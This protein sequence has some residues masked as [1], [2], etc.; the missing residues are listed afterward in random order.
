[1]G[2]ECGL[3]KTIRKGI[4]DKL[5]FE[6]RHESS[7]STSHVDIFRSVPERKNGRYKGPEAK[8]CFP[9][10]RNSKTSVPRLKFT[11]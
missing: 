8:A 7:E 5:T 4:S 9:Y 10:S 6:Q 2:E 1:M 3:H 11:G